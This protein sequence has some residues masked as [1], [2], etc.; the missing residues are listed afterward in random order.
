[1]A[2]MDEQPVNPLTRVIHAQYVERPD[3]L[4]APHDNTFRDTPRR[5]DAHP[6]AAVI[7]KLGSLLCQYGHRWNKG[8]KLIYRR[9]ILSVK[10]PCCPTC[11]KPMNESAVTIFKGKAHKS[12]YCE[13]DQNL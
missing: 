8:E 9:A 6:I 12:W 11:G 13:R 1:M 4:V 2:V 3:S 7:A 5:P 10:H